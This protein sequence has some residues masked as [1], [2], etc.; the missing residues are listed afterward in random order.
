MT[1]TAI[2]RALRIA[3]ALALTAAALAGC[4]TDGKGTPAWTAGSPG[5]SST[6]GPSAGTASPASPGA[7]A[8]AP[9]TATG[10]ASAGASAGATAAAWKTFTDPAKNV[11]FD[12]P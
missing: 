7:S 2:S 6:A 1:G 5:G 8:S 11:S 3:A 10:T 12:L 9:G 4:S